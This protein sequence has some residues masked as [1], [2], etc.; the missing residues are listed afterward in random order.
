MMVCGGPSLNDF[1]DE[2]IKLRAEGMP[3]V[4]TNG[5]YNWAIERGMKPSL[6]LIIDAR[7]FN[8]RFVRPVVDG[9]RYLI[10]S[11][12]HPEVLKG[13]PKDRTWLWHVS[14]VEEG[15]GDLL[16]ELYPEWWFPVPGG[17][18][19][20]LRGLCLLRMLG[21]SKIHMYG[22]DSCYRDGEHHAYAQPENNYEGMRIPVSLGSCGGNRTFWC[23]AWMYTQATEF[24]DQVRLMG[25]ELQL[26][27][28]GDGLIA[29]IIET[30]AKAAYADEK[31]E[32]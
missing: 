14:G 25:D 13:L 22:F 23:D 6:Q 16:D 12:C 10:A 18:T 24:I 8:K 31:H 17:S 26:N 9:C 32:D 5:T 27:V 3:M 19:V 1:E 30:G 11:Q 2:I 28:K 21:F 15:V 20:T 7:E 4:T 29:H